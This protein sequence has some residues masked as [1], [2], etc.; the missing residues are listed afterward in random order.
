MKNEFTD[1]YIDHWTGK[2]DNDVMMKDESEYADRYQQ[3]KMIKYVR[4]TSEFY[5]KSHHSPGIGASFPSMAE[6]GLSQWE[7]QLHM[8]HLLLLVK[9]LLRHR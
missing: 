7:E 3:S 1:A 2:V 8:Q 5:P 6:Q 9:T 4:H